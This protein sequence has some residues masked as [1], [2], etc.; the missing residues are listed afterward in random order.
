MNSLVNAQKRRHCFPVPIPL[1]L[2]PSPVRSRTDPPLSCPLFPQVL[3]FGPCCQRSPLSSCPHHAHADMACCVC[4]RCV[5]CCAHMAP[6]LPPSSL[7]PPAIPSPNPPARER[8]ATRTSPDAP[9]STGLSVRSERATIA[10]SSESQ[11]PAE[12]R[13]PSSNDA[14]PKS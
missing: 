11:A 10:T 5:L 12:S 6:R 1:V 4:L 9:A 7:H 13:E 8:P 3:P 14:H 2:P